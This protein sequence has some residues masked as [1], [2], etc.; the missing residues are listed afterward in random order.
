M[1][2]TA[3]LRLRRWVPA[4]RAAFAAHNADPDVRRFFASV[5][6]RAESDAQA[7]TIAEHFAAHGFGSWAIEVPGVAPFVGFAGLRHVTFDAAFTPAIEIGWRLG[8]AYWGQGYATEAA[9]AALADGF[10]R[11]L[12]EVVAF[13][14]PGNIASRRVMEKIGMRHDPAGTFDHPAVPAGHPLRPHVLYRA[15]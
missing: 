6:T 5:L 11:G 10:G 1:I 3:R 12:R 9:A 7:D 15:S 4:D 8:R 2:P 13:A 14:V